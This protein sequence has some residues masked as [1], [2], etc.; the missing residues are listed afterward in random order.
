MKIKK[1]IKRTKYCLSDKNNNSNMNDDDYF[2]I[3][4]KVKKNEVTG[5]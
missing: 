5:F 4:D 3:V 1:N 2:K